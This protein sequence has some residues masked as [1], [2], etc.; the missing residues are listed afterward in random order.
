MTM[1]ARIIN[2]RKVVLPNWEN[3]GPFLIENDSLIA[4]QDRYIAAYK[5]QKPGSYNY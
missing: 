1:G 2:R 5:R 3:P 4:I